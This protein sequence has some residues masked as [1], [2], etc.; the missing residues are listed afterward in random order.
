M[1]ETGY[2]NQKVHKSLDEI[3][4]VI[5]RILDNHLYSAQFYL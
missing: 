2:F 1:V 3:N 4:I 5:N